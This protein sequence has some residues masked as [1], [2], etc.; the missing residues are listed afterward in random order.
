MSRHAVAVFALLALLA[1]TR[2]ARADATAFLGVNTTPANRQTRGLSVGMGM[3][4]V[5]FE[6]EYGNTPD[7]P[8][9]KAP[10]LTTGMGNVLLQ[11]PGTFGGV[12]PYLTAGAGYYSENLGTQHDQGLGMNTGGGVKIALAGPLRL[13]IDYRVFRLGSGSLQQA[14]QRFYAGLNLKF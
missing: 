11:T 5:G 3:L 2:P 12:Q 14:P 1:S 4:I 8:A 9:S 7:D 6:F 10:A 13:R